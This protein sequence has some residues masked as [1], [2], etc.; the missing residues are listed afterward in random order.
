MVYGGI[1]GAITTFA[2]VSGVAGAGLSSGV[3]IILGLANLLADGF[4]M[5]VSNYMGCRSENQYRAC[6]RDYETE[7][8]AVYPEGEREEIRQIYAAKGFSGEELDR[9]V[10]LITSNHGLWVN[11]MLQ[12]EHGLATED[13]NPFLAGAATFI[14]FFL[15]GA[16]P[17]VSFLVNWFKPGTF[18]APFLVSA[19]VTLLAFFSIGFF[20]G[21]YVNQRWYVSAI[22]TALIGTVAAS[23]AFAVG[24][25]LN[26]LV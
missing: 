1:D 17:L 12:E 4:S 9:L 6:V 26:G 24:Y 7:E 20:K 19:V 13:T 18:A 14:A 2:V 16:L 15:A 21:R 25:F 3:V 5:A 22:E 23:L 11:T 8:I 10:D